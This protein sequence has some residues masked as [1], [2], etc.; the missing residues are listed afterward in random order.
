MKKTTLLLGL[1]ALLAGCTNTPIDSTDASKPV[2]PGSSEVLGPKTKFYQNIDSS[3]ETVLYEV[4]IKN[5]LVSDPGFPL[6][7]HYAFDG[8]YTDRVGGERFD[9]ESAAPAAL[10]AHWSVYEDLSDAE[11]VGRFVSRIVS[12]CPKT[13]ETRGKVETS[14]QYP[15]VTS[16]QYVTEDNFTAHRYKDL[17]TIDHYYPKVC[18][19]EADLTANE[20]AAGKTVESVN[21]ENLL[22]REQ[23]TVDDDIFYQIFQYN[24]RHA[25]YQVSDKDG[26]Y[27][28]DVTGR[29]YESIMS[30]DFAAYFMGWANQ[31]SMILAKNEKSMQKVNQLAT[32]YTAGYGQNTYCIAGLDVSTLDATKSGATFSFAYTYSVE[33][34]SGNVMTMMYQVQAGIAFIDGKIRHCQVEKIYNIYVDGEPEQLS[35]SESNYDFN[36]VEEYPEYDGVRLKPSDF[37]TYTS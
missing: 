32:E 27:M 1:A 28:E 35:T 25:Q 26:K 34:Q 13:S 31:L 7:K 23:D 20:K 16:D 17:V 8:W 10:Y 33:G 3:D 4:E 14:A 15:S 29:S 18:Y 9:F 36:S 22:V 5:G 19:S 11:K 12:L 37:E 21:A 24:T 6:Y 30:I 2:N